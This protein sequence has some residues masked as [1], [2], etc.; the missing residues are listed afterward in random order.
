MLFIQAFYGSVPVINMFF[1]SM[2]PHA[3]YTGVL[4]IFLL[5]VINSRSALNMLKRHALQKEL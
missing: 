2:L 1:T 5:R 3:L 4:G